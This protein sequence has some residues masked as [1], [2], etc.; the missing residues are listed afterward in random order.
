MK[1][2]GAL[3]LA[4]AFVPVCM[5]VAV[6]A[7]PATA[8]ADLAPGKSDKAQSLAV[9]PAYK[10][11]RTLFVG[12]YYFMWKSTNGG[13]SFSLLTAAPKDIEDIAIS[14][15]FAADKTLFVASKGNIYGVGAG[16]Y[17]SVNRG[18]TW[19]KLT[20]GLPTDAIPYRL[21]ISPGF[22][23]DKTLLAMVNTDLYKSTN[24]GGSWIEDH[25]ARRHLSDGDSTTSA[26]RRRSARTAM[27]SAPRATT[28]RSP[29]RVIEARR[30]T[31]RRSMV[32][33]HRLR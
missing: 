24:A 17:R 5:L 25:A 30:G 6:A 23:A 10:T 13:S 32:V 26:S 22:A 33:G 3:R 11:D 27:S 28:T 12:G 20:S 29:I 21:R 4:R 18:A 9:S 16:I 2:T 7:L 1:R 31:C 19:Q 15:A 8:T 14:P